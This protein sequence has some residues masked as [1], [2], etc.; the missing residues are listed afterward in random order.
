MHFDPGV[1]AAVCQVVESGPVAERR[2]V[3]GRLGAWQSAA[4]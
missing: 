4:A 3:P 1:V 2:R